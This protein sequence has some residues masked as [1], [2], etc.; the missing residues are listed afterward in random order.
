MFRRKT[1]GRKLVILEDEDDEIPPTLDVSSQPPT[2]ITNN[3]EDNDIPSTLRVSS[4]LPTQITTNDDI[5]STLHVSSP[6]PTQITTNDDIPSTLQ[7]SSSP[8]PTQIV[9]AEQ[10]EVS[11]L[12]PTQVLSPPKRTTSTSSS[13]CGICLADWD[14]PQKSPMKFNDEETVYIGQ[15]NNCSHLFCYQCIFQWSQVTN[16]VIIRTSVYIF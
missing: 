1:K 10:D 4:P 12:L 6:L 11:S 15:M 5:P 8:P 7:V 16:T 14:T 3:V 9:A 2:Q 13:T